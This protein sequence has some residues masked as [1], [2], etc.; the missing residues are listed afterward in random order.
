M[1]LIL[2]IHVVWQ[3]LF[4]NE[5]V[6]TILARMI[7]TLG[8]IDMDMLLRGQETDKYF[9][10]EYVLYFINEVGFVDKYTSVINL[11]MIY[12]AVMLMNMYR[13]RMRLSILSQKGYHWS[14]T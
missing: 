14:I 10:E 5:A 2:E 1:I 3:V 8:P 12:V 11:C 4:P 9:T 6:V 13:T 7:A